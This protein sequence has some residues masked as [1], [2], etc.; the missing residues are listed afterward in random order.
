MSAG[1]ELGPP[2]A[3]TGAGREPVPPVPPEKL[4][5]KKSKQLDASHFLTHFPKDS[6]CETCSRCKMQRTPHR[7]KATDDTAGGEVDAKAFGDLAT[8]EHIV[9]GSETDFSRHGD[10]AALVCQDFSTKWIVG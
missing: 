6:R 5:P 2:T 7:R 3:A 8:A 4:P 10:T 9:L 1:R